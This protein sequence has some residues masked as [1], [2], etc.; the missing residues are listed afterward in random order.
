MVLVVIVVLFLNKVRM[1]TDGEPANT[2]YNGCCNGSGVVMVSC[3]DDNIICSRHK[4]AKSGKGFPYSI[5]SVGPG[6]DPGVQAVS[7]CR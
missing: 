6:A 1:E 3:Q 5:Q 2:I 4:A 7:A